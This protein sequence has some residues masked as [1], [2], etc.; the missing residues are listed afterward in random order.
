[1][2]IEIL[3]KKATNWLN[4]Q[5]PDSDLVISSRI[6]L[7]R[8]IKKLRF[9]KRASVI[10]RNEVL[11]QVREATEKTSILKGSLFIGTDQLDEVDKQFLV[12]RHLIS[13]ELAQSEGGSGVLISNHEIVSIMINEEDHLRMQVLHSGFQLNEVWQMISE[14]DTELEKVLPFAFSNKLGYLTSCPTNVGTGI[15]VSTMVHLPALVHTKQINKV[16]QATVKLGLAVR[17]LYGEGSEALGNLFQISNQ[18]TLGQNEKEILNQLTKV[19]GQVLNYERTQRKML[20]NNQFREVEDRVYR[21]FGILQHA[22]IMSSKEAISMFS[23]LRMGVDL[24]I[25]PTEYRI[26]L[27]ELLIATQPAHLQK[28]LN[29]KLSPQDRDIERANLIRGKLTLN[30]DQKGAD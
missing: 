20:I 21:A 30:N 14:L 10:E 8:N 18:T 25:L 3:L 16:L 26:I 2:K 29:R 5:G 19:I 17:G 24:G 28:L 7:A 12:E 11:N 1:M 9:P 13:P 4:G 6:R 22:R 23:T 27:N 15:R